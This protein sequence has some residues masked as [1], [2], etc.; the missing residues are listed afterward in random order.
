L[1]TII[2]TLNKL[3]ARHADVRALQDEDYDGSAEVK[4][5]WLGDPYQL[6]P[7]GDVQAVRPEGDYQVM[8]TE[9]K[10]RA[11]DN[12]LGEPID[13]LVSFIEG[14]AP[15]PLKPNA[16]F[17]R[18]VNLANAFEACDSESKI[19]LCYTNMQVQ[20]LNHSIAG[21]PLPEEGDKLFCSSTKQFVT[22]LRDLPLEVVDWA[23]LPYGGETLLLN[24]KY[25]TLEY[26]LKSGH[27]FCEVEDEDGNILVYAYVFG[28][29]TYKKQKE[30]LSIVATASNQ[31]IVSAH[32]GTQPAAWAKANDKDPLARRRAKAWRDFLSFNDCVVCLDFPHAITVHNSQGSTYDHV[33]VDTQDIGTLANTNWQLY[34]KLMYVALSRAAKT[35]TT[36]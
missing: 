35:V 7:V 36:N 6:P 9:N 17:I 25:R 27:N 24:T 13:L 18:G 26:L 1:L 33:F 16:N 28:H 19:I 23:N 34:L 8:L 31:A 11:E 3:V 4:V 15:T 2:F 5:L 12:P 30:E 14:A 32:R 29:Y 10:R 22:F 21:K 20:A